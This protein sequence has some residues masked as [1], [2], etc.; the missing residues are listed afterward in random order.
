MTT[1]STSATSYDNQG[2]QTASGLE[3]IDHGDSI[4]V[5]ATLHNKDDLTIST[6]RITSKLTGWEVVL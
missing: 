2:Y 6:D 5:G 1:L 3:V 4:Q